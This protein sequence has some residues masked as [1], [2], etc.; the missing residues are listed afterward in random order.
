MEMTETSLLFFYGIF[1]ASSL[2]ALAVF[3]PFNTAGLFDPKTWRTG[4]KRLIA[5]LFI[6]NLLPIFGLFFLYNS[7]LM[8]I[9]SSAGI[10]I[11]AFASL[12]VFS[13][14][15]LFHGIV[16][17]KTTSKWFYTEE[18]VERL[19]VKHEK[20]SDPWIWHLL[21]GLIYIVFTVGISFLIYFILV[22]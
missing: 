20:K 3:R 15:R 18:E 8:E 5:G 21:P 1:W 10:M 12:S 13:I 6:A 2:N 22:P 17:N 16:L 7:P 14:P 9:E 11:S 4:F 19:R